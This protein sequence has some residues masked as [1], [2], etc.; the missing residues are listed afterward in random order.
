[1]KIY[2]KTGDNGTSGLIGG[3]RV[4]KDDIRLEAYGSTDEL[5]AYLGWLV[6]ELPDENDRNFIRAIQNQL[7]RIGSSLATDQTVQEPR[8]KQ[9]VSEEMLYRLEKEIDVIQA[10][11]PEQHQFVIPG[12]NKTAS[13]CHV[14]RTIC[15]RAERQ[16]VKI[17]AI[18]ETDPSIIRYLNRLSDY[19]FVLARKACLY[20][21]PE[22]FWDP[23]K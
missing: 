1:M 7:F 18:Y 5:N 8:F 13:V 6:C 17:S 20:D 10:A 16:T 4:P 23:S 9:P 3:T 12:G 11:L 2:T 15:R 22:F 19:L 21:S 14:A